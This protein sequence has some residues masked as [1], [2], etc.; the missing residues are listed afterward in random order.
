M[1]RPIRRLI[2]ALATGALALTVLATPAAALE[3]A[4]T[5]AEPKPSL[6]AEITTECFGTP[7]T[8]PGIRWRIGN[9][10][11][12]PHVFGVVH[13]GSKVYDVVVHPGEVKTSALNAPHWEDTFQSFKV[14]WS[15]Q[16]V[17]LAQL[18]PWLNCTEP[19]LA[20]TFDATDA[21]GQ[22]CAGPLAIT[23]TNSGTQNGQ[24]KILV[25]NLVVHQAVVATDGSVTLDLV[26][27]TG[28]WIAASFLNHGLHELFFG[29]QVVECPDDPPAPPDPNDGGGDDANGGNHWNGDGADDGAGIQDD[30]GAPGGTWEPVDEPGGD[31]GEAEPEPVV[32]SFGTVDDGVAPGEEMGLDREIA[33]LSA[34]HGMRGAP[35]GSPTGPWLA[36]LGLAAALA[37]SAIALRR[38]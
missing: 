16:D 28:D 33:L 12:G 31:V 30:P 6:W 24:V 15:S 32:S 2:T 18:K 13:Q 29:I 25:G 36:V 4:P 1:S 14:V 5:P 22:P 38:L 27:A 19:D 35:T 7:A 23:V 26:A 8:T 3:L 20:V 37:V 34:R 9:N 11:N 17:V 10:T 21:E